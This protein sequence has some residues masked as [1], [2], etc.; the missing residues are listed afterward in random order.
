[1]PAWRTAIAAALW[2]AAA[3]AH[4]LAPPDAALA[5]RIH[6]IDRFV[7]AEVAA[8]GLPGVAIAVLQPG[9]APH[10][11][12]FGHDGHGRAIGAHTP[13]PI[14]SL[15]KSFTALLLRQAIEAGQLEADAPV[16]RY[17][18]WFRVADPAA[19]AR[20]TLRQLL[21]QTSGLS[22]AD[23]I[24]PL[25]RGSGESVDEIARGMAG[26]ALQQPPGERYAYSNLNYLLLAAVLQ[27]VT[28]QR[29]QTLV[30]E[31]VLDPLAMADSCTNHRGCADM[32]AQHRMWFGQP[33][34]QRST[35]PAALAPTGG[36]VASAGDMAR[37]LQMLLDEGDAPAGRILS[38]QGVAQLLAPGSPPAH[39]TLAES[40]FSFRY[41]EGWFVGPFGAA[42]DARW[43]L[44]NLASFAA[45][46]V[47]LP[48]TGEAVVVL[49]NANSE[50]PGTGSVI[51]RLPIGIVNLLRGQ[52]LPQGPSLRTAYRVFNL[53]AAA[54][55]LALALLAW[56]GLRARQAWPAGALAALAAMALIALFALGPTPS[57]LAAWAPDPSRVL[58]AAAGLLCAPLGWRSARALRRR[59]A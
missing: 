48:A 13:L 44:G 36:L 40:D 8:S 2:L 29:W 27:Q 24:A 38:A 25:L 16:Q 33:V 58:A 47:L 5:D 28:G 54:L 31:R 20:I 45:W 32:S 3:S 1:M 39:A 17:L 57:M 21:N 56:R 15:T 52:P 42:A 59:R 14:G 41:G 49:I 10:L 30:R 34:V 26:L 9:R 11:R 4:A 35:L 53:G 43:H 37:Y 12:G 55:L 22:R 19:S 46:M 51:S 50:L 23:G 7:A 18:P 6:R